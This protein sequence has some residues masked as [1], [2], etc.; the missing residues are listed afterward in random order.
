MTLSQPGIRRQDLVY[1]ES[2]GQPMTESDPTR[3]YLIYAVEVLRQYFQSRQQI[4]VSGNL[5]IYYREGDPKAVFSPDVFVIF[6]VSKRQ[7]RSYKAW[8]EGGQLPA[9]V[10]EITSRTTRRQDETDKPAL[11]AQLGVQEYFQYDP[12]ADY[13]QPQLKGRRLQNGVYQPMTPQTLPDNAVSLRSQVLGLDLRLIDPM[14][15]LAT[16]VPRLTPVAKAL[17]FFDPQTGRKLLSHTETE[18]ARQQ[19]EQ[20]LSDTEQTL[21][22]TEQALN[23][24]EQAQRNAATRLLQRGLSAEEVA[25]VLALS[26][27]AV[28]AIAEA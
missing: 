9:F 14:G 27:E 1:P 20:A 12:T 8:Q 5:F 22:D 11:Y 18:Q 15:P 23:E 24:L 4:Y 3:D 21:S 13:L 19:V 7:R 2:D 25:E 17:R 16:E 6:G 10:L 28:Q 26:V